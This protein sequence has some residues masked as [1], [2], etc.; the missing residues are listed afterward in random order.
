[1]GAER[2]EVAKVSQVQDEMTIAI[3]LRLESNKL[4]A[5]VF[6]GLHCKCVLLIL[7]YI[8]SFYS[9]SLL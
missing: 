9:K 8:F 6:G 7:K 4:L 3:I 2:R 5:N 1:L